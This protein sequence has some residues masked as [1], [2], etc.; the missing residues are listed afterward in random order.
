MARTDRSLGAPSRSPF[1]FLCLLPSFPSRPAEPAT[2]SSCP[3]GYENSAAGRHAQDWP[4]ALYP[5][6]SRGEL[7]FLHQFGHPLPILLCREALP[8]RQTAQDVFAR[9]RAALDS[10]QLTAMRVIS[11]AA[12][13]TLSVGNEALTLGNGALTL[14]DEAL[15][16]DGVTLPIGRMA[17]TAGSAS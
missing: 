10:E 13:V 3:G 7:D 8:T 9:D 1:P 16:L 15:T 12:G 14:D 11:P 6:D 5:R 4:S 2:S 17:L